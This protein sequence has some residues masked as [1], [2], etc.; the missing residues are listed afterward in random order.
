MQILYLIR[1]GETAHN[2]DGLVQ[3]HTE[4][5]L[6]DLGREQAARV[7]GRLSRVPLVA[8]YS[9]PLRRAWDTCQA[10][11]GDRMEATAHLGLR[12]MNL[13]VWEGK[14]ATALRKLY[15]AD[16]KEWFHRPTRVNIEGAETIRVFRNRVVGTMNEIL[17]AHDA[18]S[19]AVFAHGGVICSYLTSV[20]NMR[21]DDI[22]RFKIRNGSVTRVLFQM[23]SAR[24]DLVGDVHHLEGLV[25][26]P[27]TKSFRLFP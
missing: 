8:A 19:V 9:S 15:P 1:H 18:G 10:A 23:E 16:V 27:P 5:D 25:R 11:I 2:R 22:W 24:V 17:D 14:K 3:G 26:H 20:L 21:L 13:G 4:S 12:E 6:S 7:A